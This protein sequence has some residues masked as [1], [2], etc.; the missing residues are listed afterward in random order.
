LTTDELVQN[1]IRT[2]ENDGVYDDKY[3]RTVYS[4]DGVDVFSLSLNDETRDVRYVKVD[5]R[6]ADV[7][8]F[9]VKPVTVLRT[10]YRRV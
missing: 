4:V 9:E 7:L 5:Y 10:E 3:A 6:D 2:I 1:F 8:A